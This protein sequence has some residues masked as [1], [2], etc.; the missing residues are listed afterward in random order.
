MSET[1]QS[2]VAEALQLALDLNDLRNIITLEDLRYSHRVLKNLKEMPKLKPPEK[3]MKL[4]EIAPQLKEEEAEEETP[5]E[6][7]TQPRWRGLRWR[8]QKR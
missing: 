4:S 3:P 1:L 6:T 7:E 5:E 2:D 8:K